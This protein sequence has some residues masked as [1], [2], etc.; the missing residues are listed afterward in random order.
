[1]GNPSSNRLIDPLTIGETP[2]IP[3]RLVKAAMTEG[4]ATPDG[5]PSEQLL[6]LYERWGN[7]G[8]GVQI[9]GNVQIDRQHLERPGNVV[10]DRELPD[11]QLRLFELWVASATKGGAQI[12]MQISHAGRQTQRIVNPRPKA[13]S[14]VPLAL[15]LRLFG[16]PDPLTED[17]IHVL[18]G[19]FVQAT[20]VARQTGFHGVQIHA[21]H[22][23]LLSQFLSP[24]SNVRTDQWGGSLENRS[25]FLLEVVR[26]VRE[27]AGSAMVVCV[28][29]NSADFQN[30]GF[31]SEDSLQVAG[32]LEEAGVDVLEISGGSY[33]RPRMMNMSGMG[34]GEIVREAASTAAREA[35][36]LDFADQ[37][38]RTVRIPLMV[39]GGFRTQ[40]AMAEAVSAHGVSLI[41]LARPLCVDPDGPRRVL[42]EGQDLV[43]P[44]DGLNLGPGWF[45]PASP[46]NTF[47]ALN[48]FG[49]MSWYY[50]QL[51]RMGEGSDPDPKLGVLSA[52]VREQWKTIQDLKVMKKALPQ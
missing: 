33:E 23:Y 40:S 7:G 39:T 34:E 31:E 15:P 18:I 36:F 46:I 52:F 51:R 14:A 21:A 28:K 11:E 32:W 24:L 3:N 30:G 35:Y 44:E 16:P 4:L 38:R 9:T 41:G 2:T 12:W 45:G 22:G 10:I 29:L 17:E 20:K 8:I 48:A 5:L 26:Q 37:L 13:P 6:R 1:M 50:Q 47:K 27:A 49:V 42:K 19:R 43:R 25:R